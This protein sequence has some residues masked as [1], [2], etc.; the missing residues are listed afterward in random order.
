VRGG[1]RGLA[2][3]VHGA[4]GVL[5]TKII[6]SPVQRRTTASRVAPALALGVVCSL[7]VR[8]SRALWAGPSLVGCTRPSGVPLCGPPEQAAHTVR[9]GPHAWF[10]PSGHE[11][12]FNPFL[13]PG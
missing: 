7:A 10:R 6:G 11:I 3:W 4:S 12:N 13:F 8:G 9:I 1:S 5:A 2:L